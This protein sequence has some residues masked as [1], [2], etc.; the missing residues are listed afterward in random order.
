MV[1]DKSLNYSNGNNQIIKGKTLHLKKKNDGHYGIE[2]KIWFFR[3][4]IL[5]F[6]H[7]VN[8]L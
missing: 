6:N 2:S 8:V 4:I 3:K 5:S 1:L 7:F